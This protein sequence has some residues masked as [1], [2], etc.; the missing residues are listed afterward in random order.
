MD[1]DILIAK[2]F[3]GELSSTEQQELTML[4]E[5]DPD[6]KTEFEL[7]VDIQKA[8]K[9]SNREEKK[10]L[11]EQ[12]E[13][14]RM[15]DNHTVTSKRKW[16]PI[17]AAIALLF[18]LGIYI[19]TNISPNGPE[20]YDDY[21]ELYPN[22]V[23]SIT[24]SGGEVS[25]ER[26]AFEAYESG[27]YASAIGFFSQLQNTSRLKNINFYMGQAYLANSEYQNAINA[28]KEVV[29]VNED[30]TQESRWYVSLA[31]LKLDDLENAKTALVE[32]SEKNSYKK[33]EAQALL[34]ELD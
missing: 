15:V 27:D 14:D 20:L 16:L 33:E 22:T 9:L 30:F 2:Y 13:K 32:V 23:Y 26:S 5:S 7:Q 28:F 34:K 21:Y 4:L 3:S 1:K 6:F 25:I 19:G 12:Y 18:S 11:L 10:T 31:Y 24:R 8:I 29:N 17:A